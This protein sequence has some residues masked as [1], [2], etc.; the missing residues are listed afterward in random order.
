MSHW[1]DS[2]PKKSRCKRDSNPGSSALE[3]D[4]L[5]LGQRGSVPVVK[6][7]TSRTADLGFDSSLRRGDF[8]GSSHTSDFKT[9]A[10]IAALPGTWRYR[11]SAGTGLPGVNIICDWMR[12]KV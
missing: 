11:V 8:S 5:P 2:T 7:S 10:P 4:T 9:G 1:Y 6:A 3:V 12:Y